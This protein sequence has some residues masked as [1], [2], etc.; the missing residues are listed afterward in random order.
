MLYLWIWIYKTTSE[1]KKLEKSYLL[2]HNVLNKNS[3]RWMIKSLLLQDMW[4]SFYHITQSW[5]QI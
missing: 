5:D 2:S 3:E 1:L 4:N